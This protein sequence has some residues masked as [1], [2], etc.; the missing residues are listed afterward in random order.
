[1]ITR[2]NFRKHAVM[3]QTSFAQIPPSAELRVA[4]E[5]LGESWLEN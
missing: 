5:A 4:A 2:R 3:R 1:M